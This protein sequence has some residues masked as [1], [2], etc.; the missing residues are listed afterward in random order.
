MAWHWI[1]FPR[2]CEKLTLNSG[3]TP[4]GALGYSPPPI[5]DGATLLR[6]RHLILGCSTPIGLMQHPISPRALGWRRLAAAA[7]ILLMVSGCAG[8]LRASRLPPELLAP[9]ALDLDTINLSGLP[10]QSVS[11]EVL[12]PGDLLDVTMVTDYT[13]LTTT[14]T[15]VRVGEDGS[16]V[17]PLV[18]N[19]RV[20]GMEVDQAEQTVNGESIA[21]GIFRNPC[22]TLAMKECRTR[23]VTVSGAVKNPGT[24]ELRRGS[25]S[26]MAA[27]M[28]AN[29]LSKDAGTLVEIRHTDSR[30][31]AQAGRQPALT[32]PAVGPGGA[33]A[34]VA[35]EQPAADPASEVVRVDLGVGEPRASSGA[36]TSRR[37][38]GLCRQAC[39]AADLRHR[40]GD[41]ARL[42]PLSARP[43]NTGVG[44]RSPW[45]A[46]APTPWPRRYWSFAVCPAQ[47]TG[48]HRRQPPRCKEWQRQHRP[49]AGRH[50][51]GRAH[52]RDGPLG[53]DPDVL[54]L[55]HRRKSSVVLDRKAAL[56]RFLLRVVDGGLA[57]TIFVVPLLMGGRH[58]I[59]QLV[60]TI[61][62]VA[63]AWAWAARQCSARRR[64][65]GDR[66]GRRRWC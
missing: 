46:A 27:L 8:R 9:A 16:I 54:P 51:F 15:P 65:H 3:L 31:I 4:G 6:S 40:A 21:R 49:S 41:E 66:P 24:I 39:A 32:P 1:P 35:Y 58:A 59:G 12:Q 38:R 42:V 50:R 28:A 64:R 47:G 22:I 61:L 34:T 7:M 11:S 48:P 30:H 60:L 53:N 10:A 17:I 19:V 57:G 37:R 25:T 2:H 23:K 14:T 45:R 26:L 63:A 43:G 20:G 55:Q 52:A 33:A 13:K 36:G 5:R 44:R 62:A 56:D 29:G 18:G